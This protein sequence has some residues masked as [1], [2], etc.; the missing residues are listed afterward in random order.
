[1]LGRGCAIEW[2]VGY[3]SEFV[4][5]GGVTYLKWL[6]KFSKKWRLLPHLKIIQVRIHRWQNISCPTSLEQMKMSF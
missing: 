6:R 5:R 4:N 3:F 1:M 2:G